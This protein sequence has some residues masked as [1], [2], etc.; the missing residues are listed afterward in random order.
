MTERWPLVLERGVAGLA[1]E[2]DD[3]SG[4]VAVF[5]AS[6]RGGLVAV[7]D[8]LGHGD[9]A[10]D[11]AEAAAEVLHAQVD[12]PPQELLERCHEALRR[13]RGAVMTLAW[14]DLEAA[15]DGVDRGRQR[16]GAV[17]ARGRPR[18]RAA[19]LAGRARRR[20]RLQ[21]AAGA[22]GDDP[23]RAGRRGGA[24]HRRRGAPTTRSRSSPGSPPRSWPS[25]C[26]SATARAPTT[27]SPSSCATSVP[28]AR[29]VVTAPPGGVA[30]PGERFPHPRPALAAPRE[31]CN[32]VGRGRPR[33]DI[34]GHELPTQPRRT[35]RHDGAR[36]TE[37]PPSSAGSSSSSSPPSPAR[38]SPEGPR[39]RPRWATASPSASMQIIEAADFPETVGEQVL[40]QGKGSIKADDPEVTAAVKDTVQRLEGIDGVTDI[41]SPLNASRPRRH[42]LRGRPLRGRQLQP[43]RRRRGRGEARSS[44]PR[45][46]SPRSPRSRRLIPSCASRSTAAPPSAT[47]SPSRRADEA[48]SM[49]LSFGGTL[50]ILL[51]AFGADGRRRRPA[52]PRP[53][54]GRRHHRPARAG[55]P[56][57]RPSSRRSRRS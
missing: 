20:G 54:L 1:H 32:P 21:P 5:A 19:R 15:H 25:A 23:A 51:L 34:P 30:A 43:A 44:R 57:L 12:D 36:S 6:E 37:R 49:Q 56:A 46:R 27:R 55:Q 35:R 22:D 40:I 38:A 4:D 16:R 17:R 2:G 45:R 31:A 29:V 48:K 42:R 53:D 41:Q 28:P 26:S 24:R 47:R 7:I 9:A 39:R 10:A 52:V 50:I 8:G 3:R 13:T 14:F 33:W 18:R 11:A